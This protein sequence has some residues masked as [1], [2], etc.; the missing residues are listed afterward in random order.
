MYVMLSGQ[1]SKACIQAEKVPPT[2]TMETCDTGTSKV[3][4]PLIPWRRCN[5]STSRYL[6]LFVSSEICVP[7]HAHVQLDVSKQH[8]VRLVVVKVKSEHHGLQR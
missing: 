4:P 5:V 6:Q 8:V 3:N 1:T 7:W 2:S